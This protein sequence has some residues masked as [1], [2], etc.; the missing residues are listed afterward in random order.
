MRAC[1]DVCV[2]RQP[3]FDRNLR[4]HGY[5]LLFRLFRYRG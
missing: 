1:V 4:V 5:E 2:A 3:I